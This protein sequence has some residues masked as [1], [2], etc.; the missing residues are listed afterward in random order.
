VNGGRLEQRIRREGSIKE[1][2]ALRIG[3]AFGQNAVLTGD[4]G[5]PARLRWCVRRQA[6]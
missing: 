3:A 1:E 4:A 2:E 6:D 5:Q